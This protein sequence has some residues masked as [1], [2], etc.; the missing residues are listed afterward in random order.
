MTWI[1]SRAAEGAM[2]LDVE[3]STDILDHATVSSWAGRY[4]D[5]LTLLARDSRQPLPVLRA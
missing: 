5:L 3:Y 1:V 4:V 2:R